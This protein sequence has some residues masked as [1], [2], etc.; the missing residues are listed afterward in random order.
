[1]LKTPSFLDVT[2]LDEEMATDI[3]YKVLRKLYY[4][5]PLDSLNVQK[6]YPD[7]KYAPFPFFQ[8]IMFGK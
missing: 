4:H 2:N 7:V 1:M 6:E 3:P 5:N 8:S